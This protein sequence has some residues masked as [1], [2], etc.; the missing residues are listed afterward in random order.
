MKD[1]LIEACLDVIR[2]ELQLQGVSGASWIK[3][4]IVT[5]VTRVVFSINHSS[6]FL[7]L[8]GI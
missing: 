3:R 4:D 8:C 6:F 2:Q 5:I 1:N 7:L